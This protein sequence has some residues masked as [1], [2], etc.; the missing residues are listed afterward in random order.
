MICW[1]GTSVKM[2]ALLSRPSRQVGS[3]ASSIL[4]WEG[5]SQKSYLYQNLA[6]LGPPL[7]MGWPGRQSFEQNLI[8]NE[9]NDL[10]GSSGLKQIVPTDDQ[11]C[12]E[13]A[14]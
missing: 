3:P 6:F 14:R 4:I 11:M 7:H 8:A 2:H 13:T 12:L 10:A 5:K 1:V 9:I